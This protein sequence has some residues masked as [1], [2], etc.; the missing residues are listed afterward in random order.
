MSGRRRRR[1]ATA[2]VVAAGLL[3]AAGGCGVA[4]SA[5]TGVAEAIIELGD[6]VNALRQDNALLQAQIDS[7]RAQ[8]A[9]QDSLIARLTVR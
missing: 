9:R 5:D 3:G 4:P 2:V 8:V 7:L 6:A 1:L